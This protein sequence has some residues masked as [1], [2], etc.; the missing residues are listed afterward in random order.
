MATF[1]AVAVGVLYALSPLAVWFGLAAWAIVTWAGRG[2]PDD[3]RRLIRSLLTVAI[4]LRVAAVVGLFAVTNH[5]RVP[6]ATFFG[7]EEFFIRRSIWLRN[8]AL[9]L[10]VH[11]A[12]LL[13]SFDEVGETSYLYVLAL[14]QILVGPSPYGV[15]LVGI[16]CYIAATVV[17]YRF[18][19]PALGTMPA[20]VGL[21]VLLFLPSLF[22]WSITALKE[23]AD[24]LLTVSSLAAAV[25]VVRDR[26]WRTKI[27]AL[28]IVLGV[29]LTAGTFRRF[30]GALTSASLIGGLLAAA[31]AVRPRLV[32][33]LG[34]L[35]I[36]LGLA[37]S[38]P[39]VQVWAL[40]VI[41]QGAWQQQGHINTP[42]FVYKTLD[43]RFY[44][45]TRDI[46]DIG[47]AEA[48]RFVV[49]AIGAYLVVP[50]PWAIQSRS[51]LAYVPEQIVWYVLAALVPAGVFFSLRRDA[52]VTAL[53]FSYASVWSFVIAITSGNI[54]TL[55][56][57]RSMAIP[58]LVWISAVG[59]SEL[60]CRLP[61][62]RRT[63]AEEEFAKLS[64]T[65]TEG[66]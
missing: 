7:D 45:N 2:L 15:H 48:G 24:L 41:R 35:P 5:A 57:H 60:L 55:I 54:G 14:I 17:L 47:F 18:V 64:R 52:L 40:D 26:S 65:R 36:L 59:G 32:L 46:D 34:V 12:D 10:P 8:I 13:Y 39:E 44:I 6:F 61:R 3:E 63:G 25:H 1:A 56:R 51:A 16:A 29:V 53:L 42:G 27:G 30:G 58:Y 4:I 62:A 49:R 66:I 9:G 28:L 21:V 37:G 38:R 33:A 31:V 11:G 23:P 19:R 20:L 22:A 50:L 43:D